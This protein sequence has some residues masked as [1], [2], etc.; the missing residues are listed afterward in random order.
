[1]HWCQWCDPDYVSRALGHVVPCCKPRT[2]V[3]LACLSFLFV[4]VADLLFVGKREPSVAVVI[5]PADRWGA[6]RHHIGTPWNPVVVV[7]Q[8]AMCASSHPWR[9]VTDLLLGWLTKAPNSPKSVD[10]VNCRSMH[11]SLVPK[12]CFA[13]AIFF[14][15]FL[16][17][18]GFIESVTELGTFKH[19]SPLLLG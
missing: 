8:R 3:T 7:L 17:T 16:I 14:S 6:T 9:K 5:H 15:V 18:S 11:A 4:S 1:V 19:K 10:E 13:Y 12:T 2:P